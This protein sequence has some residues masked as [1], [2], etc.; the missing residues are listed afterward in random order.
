MG[1]VN[2][3]LERGPVGYEP[4]QPRIVLILKSIVTPASVP[5]DYAYYGLPHPWLQVRA[6]SLSLLC[7]DSGPVFCHNGDTVITNLTRHSNITSAR[8]VRV[9]C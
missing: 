9:F 4:L 7:S 1:L 2:G 8:V 3:I 5:K 6:F